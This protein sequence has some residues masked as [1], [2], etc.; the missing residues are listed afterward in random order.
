M[1]RGGPL[2]RR[3]PLRRA[4]NALARTPLAKRSTKQARRERLLAEASREAQNRANGLCEARWTP[5]CRVRG[6]QAHHVRRRSQGGSDSPSN[7][8]W[9]CSP[10]HDAIHEHPQ[11]ARDRGFLARGSGQ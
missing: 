10:C 3:T 1:R 9:V 5:N 2:E 11:H 4:A 8:L 7:L 6:S